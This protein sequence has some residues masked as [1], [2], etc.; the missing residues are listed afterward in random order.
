MSRKSVHLTL[1]EFERLIQSLV[2]SPEYHTTYVFEN[3][4]ICDE[5]CRYF[6][7]GL[8]FEGTD[9]E[10][11]FMIY[12]EMSTDAF[13]QERWLNREVDY[14]VPIGVNKVAVCLKPVET[15]EEENSDG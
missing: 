8:S 6:T 12:G 13:I 11:R 1:G 3:E 4:D 15:D 9:L 2:S 5:W 10:V 14:F 7:E